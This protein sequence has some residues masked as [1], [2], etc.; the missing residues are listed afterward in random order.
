MSKQATTLDASNPEG[1]AQPIVYKA[2]EYVKPSPYE[3]YVLVREY[4]TLYYLD[5][6]VVRET[7][8]METPFEQVVRAFDGYMRKTEGLLTGLFHAPEQAQECARKIDDLYGKAV[9]VNGNQ[10][11]MAL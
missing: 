6:R 11:S 3:D 5:G 7:L 4:R 2:F 9:E 10:L 1:P 8:L